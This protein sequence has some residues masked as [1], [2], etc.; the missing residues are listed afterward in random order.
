[1][2][3]DERIDKVWPV[4]M[5][6]YYS[7]T[8]KNSEPMQGRHRQTRK[9]LREIKG[10][11]SFPVCEIPRTGQSTETESRLPVPRVEEDRRAAGSLEGN[12]K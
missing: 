5:M 6:K 3:M 7:A 1:M 8:K 10:R 2:D 12:K 9:T 4:C 11:V